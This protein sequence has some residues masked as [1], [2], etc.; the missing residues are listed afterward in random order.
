[1]LDQ[2]LCRFIRHYFLDKKHNEILVYK[3][4]TKQLKY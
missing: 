2:K 4:Q 1:M 3:Q